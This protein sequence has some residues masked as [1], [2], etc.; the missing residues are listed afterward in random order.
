MPP[1]SQQQSGGSK[2]L[3]E[4]EA[5]TLRQRRARLRD[6][7]ESWGNIVYEA[8]MKVGGLVTALLL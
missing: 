7:C 5:I 4:M 1:G 8:S 3:A 6:H 2:S